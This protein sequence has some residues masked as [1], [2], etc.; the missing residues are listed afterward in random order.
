MGK[1]S[2]TLGQVFQCFI[3]DY[4]QQYPLNAYQQK[5]VGDI[6]YCRTEIMGGHW[7]VCD[8]CGEIKKHYNFPPCG[9]GYAVTAIVQ[10]ARE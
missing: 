9:T 10:P 4:K 6:Q 5:V 3:D 8:N 1:V 7:S 2:H